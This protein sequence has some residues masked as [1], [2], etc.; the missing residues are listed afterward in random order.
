MKKYK[1]NGEFVKTTFGF[2]KVEENAE[3]PLWWYN[4]ECSL[5]KGNT[6]IEAIKVEYKG[7]EFCIANHFG[8]G[9]YKLINGGWPDKTHFSLPLET[10]IPNEGK[11]MSYLETRKFD[12]EKYSEHES[13][14][15]N[16][17]KYAYPEEFKR[18]QSLK[19]MI[20]K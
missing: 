18:M 9:V 3:K 12:E 5:T 6:Y 20:I 16:W 19:N 14:R 2:C 7:Q 13:N 10:F 15:H 8:I 1:W 11:T 17:Q 4:Y